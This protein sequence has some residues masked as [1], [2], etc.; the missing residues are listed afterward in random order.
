MVITQ[1]LPTNQTIKEKSYVTVFR[2]PAAGC[3]DGQ[4]PQCIHPPSQELWQ[5]IKSEDDVS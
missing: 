3:L 5:D 4:T 2:R 1:L